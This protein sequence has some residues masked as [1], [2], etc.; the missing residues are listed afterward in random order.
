MP[1]L[2]KE[3]IYLLDAHEDLNEEQARFCGSLFYGKCISG[4]H[5]DGSGCVA[6]V[7]ADSQ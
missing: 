6:S 7:S 3:G 5:P 1:L 2:R 4:T